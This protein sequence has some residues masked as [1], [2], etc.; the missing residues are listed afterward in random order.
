MIKRRYQVVYTLLRPVFRLFTRLSYHY[1]ALPAPKLRKGQAAMILANH[2]GAMDPFFMALSFRRP[3]FFV[4]SDHI[5]RLGIVSAVIRFL[6]AP[7]PIVKSQLD[8]RALRQI[9]EIIQS[10][11][12]IGLF[13]EGNRS[14]SGQTMHIPP[15]TGKL[16]KQLK[17]TL[18]LY[19]LDGGYLTTPR[20]ALYRRKGF[21][22]GQVVRCIEPDEL[23]SLSAEEVYQLICEALQVDPFEQQ[24]RLQIPYRGRRLAE[25]LELT[26][27]VCP[28]CHSLATLSSAD[29]R[30]HCTCGLAVRYTELGFF[31]PLDSWSVQQR[32][33]GLF[34]DNIAVWDQWQRKILPELLFDNQALDATGHKPLFVDRGQKLVLTERAARSQVMATGSLLLYADR[35]AFIADE[36][37][38]DPKADHENNEK[39]GQAD[40]GKAGQVNEDKADYSF[41]VASIS[42]IIVHGQLTLQFTTRDDVVWE[43]RSQTRRSAYKYVLVFHLLQ[44]QL[45]G[46]P[47]GFLS[48]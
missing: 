7:I 34:L 31:E 15:S 32:S 2:N 33:D 20:W 21:M 39:I 18:I 23:A 1:T 28:R 38:A 35:L 4:A 6:V 43:I 5:F 22:Q 19:R 36:G 29:D 9:R 48:I 16:I 25:T 30:F 41:H 26:L 8:L 40:E 42:R 3:I 13:P 27:F 14:F 44:Q 24:R 10:G 17:C 12:L 11:G 45:K 46:E 37:K 47:Y